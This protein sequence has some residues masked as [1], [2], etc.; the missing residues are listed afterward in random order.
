M[1]YNLLLGP[2]MRRIVYLLELS[3]VMLCYP[4]E[5]C[6]REPGR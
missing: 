4:L 1:A 3:V 2:I 5:V 6:S